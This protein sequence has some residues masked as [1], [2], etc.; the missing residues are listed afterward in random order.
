[1]CCQP[2][3]GAIRHLRGDSASNSARST[4]RKAEAEPAQPSES[5]LNRDETAG[6]IVDFPAAPKEVHNRETVGTENNEI[7]PSLEISPNTN[8]RHD[9]EVSET[10]LDILNQNYPLAADVHETNA[11]DLI[12]S[13]ENPPD[14]SAPPVDISVRAHTHRQTNKYKFVSK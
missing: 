12:P 10:E 1:M 5:K 11:R 4:P 2:P 8:D 7:S 13:D 14:L 9:E 3:T 6:E